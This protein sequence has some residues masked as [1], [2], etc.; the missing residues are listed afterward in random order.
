MQFEAQARIAT[1]MYT[2]TLREQ[3]EFATKK[4]A[5]CVSPN[6]YYTIHSH[7]IKRNSVE[8]LLFVVWLKFAIL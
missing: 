1:K 7:H 8:I 5:D 4:C 3:T 2:Y 6:S